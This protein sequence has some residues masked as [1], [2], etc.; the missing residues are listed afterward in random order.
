MC[1]LYL[2]D[3]KPGNV[4]HSN[5]EVLAGLIQRKTAINMT[6]LIS[7]T[8]MQYAAGILIP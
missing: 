3:L 2:E 5:E 8:T 6:L 4:E 1:A 7:I